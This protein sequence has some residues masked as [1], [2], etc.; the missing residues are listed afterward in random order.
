MGRKRSPRKSPAQRKSSSQ[1]S[2]LQRKRAS[3]EVH[4]YCAILYVNG[5]S[6][7]LLKRLENHSQEIE[8]KTGDLIHFVF[9]G[10]PH[11][12]SIAGRKASQALLKDWEKRMSR[13]QSAEAA[14]AEAAEEYR[15]AADLTDDD[16]PCLLLTTAD[17]A[18]VGGVKIPPRTVATDPASAETADYLVDALSKE[19]LLK[20]LADCSDGESEHRA[21][22]GYCAHMTTELSGFAKDLTSADRLGRPSYVQLKRLSDDRPHTVGCKQPPLSVPPGEKPPLCPCQYQSLSDSMQEC[23][24]NLSNPPAAFGG[25]RADQI[26]RMLLRSP[27]GRI[28]GD[29]LVH[30]FGGSG[31]PEGAVNSAW[32]VLKRRWPD[33]RPFLRMALNKSED[34]ICVKAEHLQDV[35][36]Q[37]P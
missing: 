8:R 25:H 21:I 18:Y 16:L 35:T 27:E 5:R 34:A 1:Q 24:R 23:I 32:R 15:R 33:L 2:S 10:N 12:Q 17:F 9:P 13:L 4:R 26:L 3:R 20:T 7:P 30:R 36:E 6:I 29:E 11:H 19:A 37:V 28:A 31:T 22:A 14:I